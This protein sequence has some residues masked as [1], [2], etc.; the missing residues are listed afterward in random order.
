MFGKILFGLEVLVAMGAVVAAQLMLALQVDLDV[1][2]VP[3]RVVTQV[4]DVPPLL[5]KVTRHVG[6]IEVHNV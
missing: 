2:S 1:V 5:Q 3:G 4:T 6:S